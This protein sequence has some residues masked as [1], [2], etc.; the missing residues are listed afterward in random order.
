MA[1][2]LTLLSWEESEAGQ[3]GGG[4]HRHQVNGHR[5]A[6]SSPPLVGGARGGGKG[7]IAGCSSPPVLS[8]QGGGTCY[9]SLR[10]GD[11]LACPP[12]LDACGARRRRTG[13]GR[14]RSGLSLH[15]APKLKRHSL[16]STSPLSAGGRAWPRSAISGRA[17][18]RSTAGRLPRALGRGGA[19][20]MC[21]D[22]PRSAGQSV[23]E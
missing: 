4:A 20:P 5:A 23:V 7:D 8:H 22:H 9:S 10:G 16:P 3:E 21:C 19:G 13:V 1:F 2:A 11:H 15:A 6:Q 14:G 18:S 17:A 12:L